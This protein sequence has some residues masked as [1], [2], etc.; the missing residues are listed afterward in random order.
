MAVSQ[1]AA[2]TG[3]LYRVTFRSGVSLPLIV[4]EVSCHYFFPLVDHL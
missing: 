4:Q 1:T 2:Y 3:T